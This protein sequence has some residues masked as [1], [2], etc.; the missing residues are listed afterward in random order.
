PADPEKIVFGVTPGVI[1][2]LA[3]AIEGLG[4]GDSFDV[5]VD[6]A[7][8]FG[9]RDPERVA[10]LEKEIFEIDG[11]FDSR[12]KV[13]AL[14][15]MQTAE[16]FQMVGLVTEITDKEVAMDFNHPL[17]GRTIKLRGNVIELRPATAEEVAV[18]TQMGQC[19][20]GGCGGGDCGGGECG[21]NGCCDGCGK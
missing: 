9:P 6:S 12:V 20:C 2:P 4:Q 18:H 13:G 7:D 21:S 1:E 14:L 16:G 11:K 15:P 17:A 3:A 8:A 19:G 5:Y 10:H